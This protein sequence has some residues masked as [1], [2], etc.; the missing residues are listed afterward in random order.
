MDSKKYI[1]TDVHKERVSIAV[2]N[3]A[4]K[5][6]MECVIETKAR[7]I[8]QFVS[9]LR[10]GLHVTFEEGTSGRLAVRLAETA[11][12]EIGGVRFAKE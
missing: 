5:I 12:D 3:G 11:R 8:L 4:G 1:G 7:M 9:G 2:M 10:G 6:G